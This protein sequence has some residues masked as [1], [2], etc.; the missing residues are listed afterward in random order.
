MGVIP[1]LLTVGEKP[2]EGEPDEDGEVEGLAEAAAGALVLDAVEEVDEF[3]VVE[4]AVAADDDASGL[5]IER[6][7]T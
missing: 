6:A 1:V 7:L 3:V 4:L 5:A 2:G